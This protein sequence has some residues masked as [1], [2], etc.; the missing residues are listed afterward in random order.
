M[1]YNE[2]QAAELVETVLVEWSFSP[3]LCRLVRDGMARLGFVECWHT[4]E[5]READWAEAMARV[6]DTG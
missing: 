2:T 1:P 6:P 3:K 4:E 5:A